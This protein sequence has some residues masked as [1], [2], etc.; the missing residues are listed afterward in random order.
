MINLILSQILNYSLVFSKSIKPDIIKATYSFQT[1][2]GNSESDINKKFSQIEDILK[3]SKYKYDLKDTRIMPLY[4]IEG[5]SEKRVISGYMGYWNIEF[6]LKDE[7][8]IK[9]L[10][11]FLSKNLKKAEVSFELKSTDSS[12]SDSLLLQEKLKYMK[13][14][15]DNIKQQA[16]LINENCSIEKIEFQDIEPT[17]NLPQISNIGKNNISF[18]VYV[19]LNC[20]QKQ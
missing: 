4:I 12:I 14:I 3:K 9:K 10:E 15:I 1:N 5:N 17:I 20:N 11:E 2:K 8:E 7:E 13:E 18:T 19:S 6:I 16:K